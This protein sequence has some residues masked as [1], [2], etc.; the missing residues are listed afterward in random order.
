MFLARSSVRKP[1]L[2]ALGRG[3]FTLIELLVVI[4]I[5]AILAALLLPALAR[6]KEKSRGVACL[7]NKKQLGLAVMMYAADANDTIVPTAPLGEMMPTWCGGSGVD[8]HMSNS[9]T[10]WHYYATNIMGQYL[11]GQIGVYRCPADVIDRK[12]TRLNS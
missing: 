3:A 5:I 2:S 10:N 11:V 7:N 8:W 1:L 12:S 9:N 4:A 6:A